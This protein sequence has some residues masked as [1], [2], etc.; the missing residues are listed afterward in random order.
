MSERGAPEFDPLRVATAGTHLVEANAGT[1]K[2]H[3]LSTLFLRLVVEGRI[4]LGAIA[5]VTFTD[6]AARE[7]RE[8]LLGRLRELSDALEHPPADGARADWVE[9][10]VAL[11]PADAARPL[12][13]RVR[14]ALLR[15][16]EVTVA[17]IHGFCRRALEGLGVATGAGESED[18]G[19]LR[20]GLVADFWRRRVLGGAADEA[21]WAL[22]H[23]DE[24]LQ[25]ARE[26]VDAHALPVAALDPPRGTA[27]LDAGAAQ[28]R[29]AREEGR[30]LYAA[31]LLD[32]TIAALEDAVFLKESGALYLDGGIDRIARTLADWFEHGDARHWP[33][34]DLELL[35]PTTVLAHY[36]PRKSPKGWDA[37]RNPLTAWADTW[38]DAAAAHDRERVAQFRHDAL[39]FVAAGMARLRADSGLHTHDDLIAGL[40][41]ALARPE[42]VARLARRWRL[43]IVDEFQD[44]DARQYAIFARI[45][46]R[47]GSG[48][49]LVGDPK[50]AI[51]RFRG[52]D[53]HAYA[54]AAQA[55]D[56]RWNLSG[57]WRADPA[58]VGA[59][60]ALFARGGAERPFLVDFIGYSPSHWPPQRELEASPWSD[61]AS[62]V[63]W[64]AP[65]E[66]RGPGPAREPMTAL[67]TQA[68]AAEI[69]RL[70][71]RAGE[72]GVAPP[73]IA[74][75]AP[76]HRD[77]AA[78]AR[79]LRDWRIPAVAQA[80]DSVYANPA[81]AD[82]EH[83]LRALLD[84]GERAFA[85]ALALPLFGLPLAQ[86]AAQR[87]QAGA[88]ANWALREELRVCWRERGPLALV[89]R[90]LA[91]VAPRWIGDAEGERRHADLLQIGELLEARRALGDGLDAGL[92]W[93]AQR[94]RAAAAG[95]AA[96][97]ERPRPLDATGAVQLLTVHASKGLQYDIVFA[98]FLWRSR[99][100]TRPRPETPVQYH[101]AAGTLRVDLGSPLLEAHRALQ[102]TEM[103]QEGLRQAYV[104]L[105]RARHRC[106]T[107]WGRCRGME[108]SPLAPLLHPDLA[109][110]GVLAATPDEAT[111]VAALARLAGAGAGA[112]EVAALPLATAP[113]LPAAVAAP[114]LA[115]RAPLRTVHAVRRTLSFTALA[116]DVGDEAADHDGADPAR[117]GDPLAEVGP[118]PAHPRGAR[119]GECVHLA[120]ERIDFANWPDAGGRASL[121]QACRRFRF[122]EA[123]REVFAE[124]IGQAAGSELLPGLRL[125]ALAPGASAR[126][127]EFHFRLGGTARA[128]EAALALDPRF[129]RDGAE[130]ARLPARMQGLMHGYIDL[131]L[132]HA[133]RWYVV[134]Y[135]TNHL[136]GELAHYAPPALA[137]AVREGDYDL[138]YLIY[139]VALHRQLRHRLG[140]AYDPERQLGGALYL[141]L[142]GMTR[143]GSHGV[144]RDRP[145]VAVIEALDRAFDH[146]GGAA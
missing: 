10:L 77:L 58:L 111:V 23:W 95:L 124:W 96:R 13:R 105:T 16:D 82:L 6:A 31:G 72:L 8:R 88:D 106:Y 115:V 116:A 132:Q 103:R 41:A 50:Q 71:E 144:H 65:H 97:D 122:G 83:L 118:I 56:A 27:A 90:L 107:L 43:G 59:I 37:P 125:A 5:L 121:E 24:P 127:L 113:V 33:L 44:T 129:A 87:A 126:E 75:L 11:A 20:D 2:T 51:Y 15:F 133:G 63:V 84:G 60:N 112:I 32:A 145:P 49:F 110:D 128:L 36:S 136:G 137:Q 3:S 34:R 67:A 45:F 99:A 134:D 101:D 135:K 30:A 91:E 28:L 142:R 46:A 1:G 141:F 104:A 139:L 47:A 117:G 21:A 57:N 52:G 4:D 48:L 14:D 19:P 17:T 61:P 120:L 109:P 22:A 94:R 92:A 7:L 53:I 140:A 18:P 40:D 29:R 69:A 12:A 66:G 100:G 131:V 143:D 108:E 78:M 114:E 35:R 42:A 98:P 25:L 85:G 38:C 74:V 80:R 79:T 26:L 54:R 93:L 55:A 119:V 70:L 89:L 68:T 62:L 102:A 81:A 64:H 86:L 39:A 146:A 130:I 76:T 138:Q 9:A 73:R 123:E